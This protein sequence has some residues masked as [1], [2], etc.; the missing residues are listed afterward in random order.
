MLSTLPPP[1]KK[2][3]GRVTLSY[4]LGQNRHYKNTYFL[5]SPWQK[6]LPSQIKRPFPPSFIAMLFAETQE[7]HT[8]AVRPKQHCTRGGEGTNLFLLDTIVAWREIGWLH[9]LYLFEVC[10]RSQKMWKMDGKWKYGVKECG[11]WG[12]V[13][14]AFEHFLRLATK[15]FKFYL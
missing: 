12:L 10:E 5:H 9:W 14:K 8:W 7:M 1:P 15:R 4:N 2:K 3:M 11:Y 13:T 6:C